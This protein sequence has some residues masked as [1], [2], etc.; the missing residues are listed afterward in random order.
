MFFGVDSRSRI[1]VG[2]D[3]VL[4]SFCGW[5]YWRRWQRLDH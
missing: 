1:I 4:F 5:L 3:F 2:A